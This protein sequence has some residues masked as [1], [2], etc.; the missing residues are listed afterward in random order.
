M[1]FVFMSKGEVLIWN[2]V[3]VSG[4]QKGREEG[5]SELLTLTSGYSQSKTH[6][7]MTFYSPRAP[8]K[9]FALSEVMEG[10]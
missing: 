9:C 4:G 1:R 7:I 3:G 2:L 8:D 5:I 6:L 10:K